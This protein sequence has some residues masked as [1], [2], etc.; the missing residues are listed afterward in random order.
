MN[1]VV[2]TLR[3]YDLTR[4]DWDNLVELVQFSGRNPILAKLDSKVRERER[5][6]A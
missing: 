1:E 6:L 3:H 5:G 2:N 4:E